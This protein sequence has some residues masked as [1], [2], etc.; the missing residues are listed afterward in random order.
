MTKSFLKMHGL[1]ND[2]AVFEQQAGEHTF[3]YDQIRFLADRK[4]GI[5]FDQMIVLS[6]TSDADIFMKI[7]NA[8]GGEVGACGN[9]SR[10]V[11][12]VLMTRTGKDFVAIKTESGLVKASRVG[13]GTGLVCVD[14]GQPRLSWAD[15]PLAQEMD[16]L[17]LD[18]KKNGLSKPCAVNMGNPHI[19]FFVED[20]GAIDLETVGSVIETDSLFPERINVEVV[21]VLSENRLRMR[22]WERGA[23]ITRACGTGACAAAVAANRR[24]LAG[25][26]V[27]VALDGGELEIDWN[28]KDNHV[29]MTGAV[30][31]VYKG[32]LI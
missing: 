8:D 20:V 1:G 30:V 11:G 2:F 23:G 21:Q 22:V 6:P 12:D 32:E 26:K 27:T 3:T 7:Y 28:E 29:L 16:T 31:T 18:Y 25:R 13:A 5:G 14:M 17:S 24:G 15:I 4:T 9:A 10:C 19:V